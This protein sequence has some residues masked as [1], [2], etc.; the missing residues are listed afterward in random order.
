MV[1]TLDQL[2]EFYTVCEDI[3]ICADGY[4]KELRDNNYRIKYLGLYG[5]YVEN[6]L[7]LGFKSFGEIARFPLF[8]KVIHGWRRI[9]K[10]TTL[11]YR[12]VCQYADIMSAKIRHTLK[13]I[14]N[15]WSAVSKLM[16]EGE[17]VDNIGAVAED[18]LYILD[19]IVA[20]FEYTVI[21]L[22]ETGKK[23]GPHD[24]F[25]VYTQNGKYS[26]TIDS[27]SE[28]YLEMVWETDNLWA[29]RVYAIG[30]YTPGDPVQLC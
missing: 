12:L 22:V 2:I 26:H 17:T 23:N 30:E 24:V 6:D 10:D 11:Q 8:K 29:A 15:H 4:L 7:V 25:D 16:R 13:Y 28:E 18:A 19:E 20:P 3:S 27:G 1:V 21:G 14:E 9:P 5:W